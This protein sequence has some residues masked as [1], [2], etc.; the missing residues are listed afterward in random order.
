MTR[1]GIPS[2]C[3]KLSRTSIRGSPLRFDPRLRSVTPSASG[4]HHF[5]FAVSQFQLRIRRPVIVIFRRRLRQDGRDGSERIYDREAITESS[6]GLQRSG[7]PRNRSTSQ[8]CILKGCQKRLGLRT[9]LGGR[10]RR[11]IPGPKGH[12][13]VNYWPVGPQ[14]RPNNSRATLYNSEIGKRSL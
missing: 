9:F 4:M 3:I 7:N 1:A 10:V 5:T 6:R 8:K 11:S 12:G 13:W 14:T 2:G